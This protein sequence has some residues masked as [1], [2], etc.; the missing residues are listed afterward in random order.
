MT[1]TATAGGA[2]ITPRRRSGVPDRPGPL[3]TTAQVARSRGRT[4][5]EAAW[6]RAATATHPRLLRFDPGSV[7]GSRADQR[8][9]GQYCGGPRTD[10]GRSTLSART[11]VSRYQ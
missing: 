9:G 2:L 10:G 1:A 6:S 5:A 11:G 4:P 7:L 8:H 3:F